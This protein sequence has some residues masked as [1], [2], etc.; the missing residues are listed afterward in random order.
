MSF[1]N[2]L[3]LSLWTRFKEV[4]TLHA[5]SLWVCRVVLLTSFVLSLHILTLC[6][7]CRPDEF[8][9]SL[10]KVCYLWIFALS[11]KSDG[12][13]SPASPNSFTL[14]HLH[15]TCACIV[16]RKIISDT[17]HWAFSFKLF[18]LH[19]PISSLHLRP[20]LRPASLLLLYQADLAHTLSQPGMDQIRSASVRT[21]DFSSLEHNKRNLGR[22]V[23]SSWTEAETC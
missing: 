4:L 16:W 11:C 3:S 7:F 6:F 15:N 13:R 23:F 2:S 21:G 22:W 5:E 10:C 14:T 1:F 9:I 8:H 17:S 19:L 20:D 18:T 12:E